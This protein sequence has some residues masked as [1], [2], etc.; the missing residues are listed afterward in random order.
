MRV[1]TVARRFNMFESKQIESVN[2]RIGKCEY[3]DGQC[4]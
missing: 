2:K 4:K 3:T 1:A